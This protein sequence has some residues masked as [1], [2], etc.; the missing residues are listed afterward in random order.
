MLN[1]E[2]A[3]ASAAERGQVCQGEFDKVPYINP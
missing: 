2:I 3:S 1:W